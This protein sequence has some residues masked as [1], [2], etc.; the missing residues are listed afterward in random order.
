M[1]SRTEAAQRRVASSHRQNSRGRRSQATR[2]TTAATRS[3]ADSHAGPTPRL[4]HFLDQCLRH[5]DN[6]NIQ[7]GTHGMLCLQQ[8]VNFVKSRGVKIPLATFRAHLGFYV[9]HDT[10]LLR[11]PVRLLDLLG[12]DFPAAEFTLHSCTEIV[13]TVMMIRLAS[14]RKRQTT[15]ML[16]PETD[17]P[18]MR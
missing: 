9:F 6:C 8:R 12:S 17:G 1:L 11:K 3:L 10:Q 16:R 18:S 14:S 5:I 4:S 7:S 13:P 2:P 15:C